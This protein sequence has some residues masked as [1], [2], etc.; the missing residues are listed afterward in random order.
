MN[1][2]VAYHL[3][4]LR[5]H[6]QAGHLDDLTIENGDETYF[7]VS[8]ENGR[9]LA[10]IGDDDMKYAEVVSGGVGMTLFVRL[11]GGAKSLVMPDF[12]IF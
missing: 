11:S 2:A 10:A 6:S 7:L 3:G 8:A 4:K 9:C 5:R 1:L 12:V